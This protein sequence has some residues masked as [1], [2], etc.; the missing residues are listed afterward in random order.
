MKRI[1]Q[2]IR[3]WRRMS[4]WKTSARIAGRRLSHQVLGLV[5]APRVTRLAAGT[6][7]ALTGSDLLHFARSWL[8]QTA[9]E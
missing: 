1:C 5:F 6:L 8:Q 2:L 3:S 4:G 7:T 9:G